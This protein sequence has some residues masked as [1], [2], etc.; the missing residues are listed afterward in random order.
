MNYRY[1][2]V[3]KTSSIFETSGIGYVV[4]FC[5]DEET[6]SWSVLYLKHKD[7]N[8]FEYFENFFKKDHFESFKRTKEWT[9][10]NYPELLL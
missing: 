4:E 6:G 3:I 8:Y 9:K 10:N 1:E 2:F 5:D 7:E